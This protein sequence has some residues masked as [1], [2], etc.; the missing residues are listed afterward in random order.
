MQGDFTVKIDRSELE[1]VHTLYS[2]QLADWRTRFEAAESRAQQREIEIESLKGL[3]R[4]VAR[5]QD[6]LARCRRDGEEERRKRAGEDSRYKGEEQMLRNRIS[7]L[8]TELKN[9]RSRGQVNLSGLDS[10]LQ[11]EYENRLKA[12]VSLKQITCVLRSQKY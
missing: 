2:G 8:E 4:E 10:K 1:S 7:V 6:E 12:E 11:G 3:E 9:E 5:L